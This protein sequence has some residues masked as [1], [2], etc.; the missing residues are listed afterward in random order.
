MASLGRGNDFGHPHP[1][2]VA[3]LASLAIPFKRTDQAGTITIRTDGRAWSLAGGEALSADSPPDPPPGPRAEPIDLNTATE[4]E[5]R[6]L[7][8]IGPRLAGRIIAARPFR[9]VEDLAN[10]PRSAAS[11]PRRSAP[12]RRRD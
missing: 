3:L 11:E 6:T 5:L 8:G 9:T 2:V 4:A 12:S 7:P 10:V 1:E